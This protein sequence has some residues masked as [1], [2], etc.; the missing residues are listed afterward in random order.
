M[1]K[2]LL[3][4]GA[5]AVT[6]VWAQGSD[7]VVP[8]DAISVHIVERGSMSIFAQASGSVTSLRPHRAVV[9]FDRGTQRCDSGRPARLVVGDD[10]RAL[11]GKVAGPIPAGGC[12]VEFVDPPPADAVIGQKI[13]A[14]IVTEELSDVVFFGRPAESEPNSTATL[15]LLDGPLR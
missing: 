4:I 11:A 7:A 13:G 1:S 3:T 6:P 10:Q 9:E 5:L 8:K 14:M 12:E 15:F 2:W